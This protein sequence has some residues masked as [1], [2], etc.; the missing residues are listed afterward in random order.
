MKAYL[1]GW[2]PVKWAWA[3]IDDDIAKLK[4]KGKLEESWSVASYKTIQSGDR[5]YI[6]RLG[7]EPKGLFASGHVS[8]APYMAFRNGRHYRRV[9]IELDIMLN[10]DKQPIL[11]LDKLKSGRLADQNWTPQ[12][13]GISIKPYLVDELE[14]VW[15]NFLDHHNFIEI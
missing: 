13:S 6:M 14:S 9:N 4:A 11:T 8:S 1:F 3:D 2:N 10:P 5:A 15:L 7:K 12:A